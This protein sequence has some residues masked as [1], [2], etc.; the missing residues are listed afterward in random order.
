MSLNC[1]EKGKVLYEGPTAAAD[2]RDEI[3]GKRAGHHDF[4]VCE[5]DQP[6]AV[7]RDYA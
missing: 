7:Q 1:M 3:T 4:A 6:R 2:Q 5:V